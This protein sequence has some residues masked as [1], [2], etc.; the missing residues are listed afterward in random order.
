MYDNEKLS[1]MIKEAVNSHYR[2]A[3]EKDLRG[4]IAERAAEELGIKKAE[5]NKMAKFAYDQTLS[6]KLAELEEIK[7]VLA[8]V[9]VEC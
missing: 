7:S 8:S 5:F 4:E 6:D 3:A 1:K 9:G 2:E